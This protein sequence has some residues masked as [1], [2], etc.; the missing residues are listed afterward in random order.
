[1]FLDREVQ[2]IPLVENFQISYFFS[3]QG[4]HDFF[5]SDYLVL[6]FLAENFTRLTV[7]SLSN[8]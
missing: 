1:M 8:F 5:Y 2:T 7:L 3:G 6:F 4:L